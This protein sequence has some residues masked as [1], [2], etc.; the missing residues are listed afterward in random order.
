MAKSENLAR[1]NDYGVNMASR[2]LQIMAWQN[3]NGGSEEEA[4]RMNIIEI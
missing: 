4:W 1:G 3:R 2:Q